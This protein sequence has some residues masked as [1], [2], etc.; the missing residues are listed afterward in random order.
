[1]SGFTT[2]ELLYP[3]TKGEGPGHEF[4]G[5]QYQMGAITGPVP[6]GIHRAG[7]REFRIGPG[8]DL[9]GNNLA[10]TILTGAN[11]KGANLSGVSLSLAKL[12][13]ADL[14]GA[15]LSGANLGEANL[16]GANLSGAN[17]T[18]AQLNM[19]WGNGANLTGANLTGANLREA[20]FNG[21]NLSG[22]DLTGA[23]LFNT[24]F[25]DAVGDE[26]TKLPDTH[27]V[28]DGFIVKRK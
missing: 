1:M 16:G 28:V 19:V 13:D 7:M 3:L 17:L 27:E 9:T 22:A 21:A 15:N 8:V 4:H 10:L 20:Y 18:G 6:D 12:R 25:M 5:N 2:N 23:N 11:L 24:L 14:S 26:N